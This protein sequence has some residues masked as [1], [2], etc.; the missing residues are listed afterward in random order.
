MARI[1][2]VLPVRV[3]WELV[4]I[5]VVAASL[6][7]A[8]AAEDEDIGSP[9][10][11]ADLTASPTTIAV[12][13]PET[14]TLSFDLVDDDGDA[15]GWD[16]QIE[17]AGRVIATVPRAP[18][19]GAFGNTAARVTAQLVVVVPSAG[20]YTLRARVLDAEDHASNTLGSELT[21]Q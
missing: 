1:E 17:S 4:L 20:L 7:C 8:C 6:L 14:V 10:V 21:A 19:V 12:A 5:T 11:I 18:I 2:C 9:P 13:T 16:A 3:G 15:D